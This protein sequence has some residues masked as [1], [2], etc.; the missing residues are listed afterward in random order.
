MKI[1]RFAKNALR[2]A[3]ARAERQG[4]CFLNTQELWKIIV[5]A[6]HKPKKGGKK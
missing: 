1:R 4:D 5:S 2:L 6:S 3:V